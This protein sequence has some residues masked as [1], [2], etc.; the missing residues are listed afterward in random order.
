VAVADVGTLAPDFS[1][2]DVTGHAEMLS[3]YRGQVVVLF[4]SSLNNSAS[5]DYDD[6]VARLADR[7]AG[8]ARVRLLCLNVTQSENADPVL[9]RLDPQVARRNFTTLLDD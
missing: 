2:P 1:L 6:R 7:Y 8:D 4:F 9:M 5:A 3:Q